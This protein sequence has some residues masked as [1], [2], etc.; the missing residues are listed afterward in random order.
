[1]PEKMVRSAHCFR[2]SGCPIRWWSS[3]PRFCLARKPENREYSRQFGSHLEN[4]GQNSM[5]RR[6]AV[7]DADLP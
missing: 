1:M 5:T 7:Y 3:S 2:P 4:S 6:M